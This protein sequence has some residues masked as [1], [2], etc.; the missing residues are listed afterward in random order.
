[1]RNHANQSYP[2]GTTTQ[3]LLTVNALAKYL[4]VSR[5]QIY[6]LPIPFVL[7]GN[8]RRYRARDVD[9]YLERGAP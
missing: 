6:N 1:M 3:T 5:R 9:A 7:V 8:R 2:E 4:E